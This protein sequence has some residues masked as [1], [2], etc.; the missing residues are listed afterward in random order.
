MSQIPA[1]ILFYGK[2]A[3]LIICLRETRILCQSPLIPLYISF[4]YDHQWLF[5]AMREGDLN[6]TLSHLFY[7]SLSFRLPLGFV[8]K[9]SGHLVPGKC[10]L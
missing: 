10:I 7:F 5:A 3:K 9:V 4:D 8:V 2:S 1:S 6:L